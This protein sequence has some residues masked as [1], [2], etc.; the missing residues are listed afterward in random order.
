MRSQIPDIIYRSEEVKDPRGRA[1]DGR[2]KRRL[3]IW[4][5]DGLAPAR[6]RRV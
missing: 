6:D 3:G 1:A 4:R 5:S 2:E